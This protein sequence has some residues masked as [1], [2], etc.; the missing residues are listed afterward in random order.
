VQK[1]LPHCSWIKKHAHQY[2]NQ[3]E[4]RFD[5]RNDRNCIGYAIF[6]NQSFYM[7][8]AVG[9]FLLVLLLSCGENYETPENSIDCGRQFIEAIFKGNFKRARQLTLPDEQNLALLNDRLAKD[10]RKRSS[11]DKDQLRNASIV[12]NEIDNVCDSVTIINFL[13]SYDNKPAILK[14]VRQNGKWLA[15][16]KYTFSGN[17]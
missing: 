6:A 14:V 9:C 11:L 13:N 12:I 1:R 2:A 7:K 17:F 16:L 10:F 8:Y 5:R 3:I 15:D 4:H